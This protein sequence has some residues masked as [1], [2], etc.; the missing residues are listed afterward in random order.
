[1]IVF[2]VC[3][4]FLC[5]NG[6]SLQAAKMDKACFSIFDDFVFFFLCSFFLGAN[7]KAIVPS[8]AKRGESY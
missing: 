5:V 1:M 4:L 8:A 7:W 6:S 2:D 3:L